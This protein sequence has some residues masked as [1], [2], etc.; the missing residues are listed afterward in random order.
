MIYFDNAAT[1]FPKPEETVR[2]MN[3]AM[4]CYGANPGRSGHRLSLVC[5]EK[6]Y[7]CRERAARLF[8]CPQPE[9]VVFTANC[10]H[11]VNLVINS[12]VPGGH[13][14]IS[15][16]EHNA[17]LRPVYHLSQIGAASYSVAE[18]FENDPDATVR[19]FAEKLRPDTRLIVL[20][21]ASNVTGAV[22]PV[23]QIAAMA[24]ERGIPV[25]VDA[26]QSAGVLPI[27]MRGDN[28]DFLCV[29]GHKG[30]YGPM[31]TGMLM[32]ARPEL[33]DAMLRGGTG[34]SSLDYA[35]PDFLPDRL[36]SGTL[37]TPGIIALSAG[38]GFV[39]RT[40]I[41]RIHEY[42]RALAEYIV[43]ELARLPE[44]ELYGA[45]RLQHGRLPVIS[46][47]LK[48][49][50]GEKTASLLSGLGIAARGGY[51]CAPLAHKKLGTLGRGVCR[52]SIGVFNSKNQA[53]ELVLAIKKL[54]SSS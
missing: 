54:I 35:Q 4:R 45:D 16:I 53:G 23:R 8:G 9:N 40:G 18:T 34:S 3:A 28:I 27:D 30:L 2:A 38:I 1:T 36:E 13:A 22:N 12:L 47:N 15:D 52:L 7:E 39:E 24:H 44:V 26:A 37:N 25:M 11:S 42:E 5:A 46:F 21:H 51:Q 41:R 6:V 33:P 43:R 32:T 31:G 14:V 20:T 10:T 19:S 50:S 48:D 49:F 29:P 17:V